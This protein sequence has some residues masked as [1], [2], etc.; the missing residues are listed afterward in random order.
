MNLHSILFF[1]LFPI[2]IEKN[3]SSVFFE[4]SFLNT[5][6]INSASVKT[7]SSKVSKNIKNFLEP[8]KVLL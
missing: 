2:L 1:K 4:V 7:K 5:S 6:V 8:F 3:I